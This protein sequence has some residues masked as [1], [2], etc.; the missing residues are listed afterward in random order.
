ML[1]MMGI[2]ISLGKHLSSLFSL[3][4]SVSGALILKRTELQKHRAC[5][6]VPS[7][8]C[9]TCDSGH[10]GVQMRISIL[11]CLTSLLYFHV[12]DC[13]RILVYT[14]LFQ[15]TCMHAYSFLVGLPLGVCVCVC[16]CERSSRLVTYIY[17]HSSSS[18][19]C[20]LGAISSSLL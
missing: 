13:F 7:A 3:F 11:P 2:L 6:V 20:L 5:V 10:S 9:L 19:F 14:A 18:F 4:L 16:V 1:P 15:L 12:L 8:P 17:I